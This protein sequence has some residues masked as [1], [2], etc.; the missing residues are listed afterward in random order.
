MGVPA[1]LICVNE[2]LFGVTGAP[3]LYFIVDLF[4]Y[5]GVTGFR[6][7][8]GDE[9]GGLLVV[10]PGI[11]WD[12]AEGVMGV[13]VVV[14]AGEGTVGTGTGSFSTSSSEGIS[15]IGADCWLVIKWQN[16]GEEKGV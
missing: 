1:V 9:I 15:N 10:T 5:C 8:G 2:T 6:I 16:F 4:G 7:M 12:G 3:L 13:V 11:K 14:I